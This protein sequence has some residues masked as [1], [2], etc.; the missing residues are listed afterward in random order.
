MDAASLSPGNYIANVCV[1]SNDTAH[2][3][4]TVHVSFEVTAVDL[5]FADGFDG[6]A[7]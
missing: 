1:N 2:P 4:T 3:V 5:I 6:T 7:P